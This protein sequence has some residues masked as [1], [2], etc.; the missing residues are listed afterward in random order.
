MFDRISCKNK[1]FAAIIMVLCVC[2]IA[3]AAVDGNYQIVVRSLGLSD[4][5]PLPTNPA[6]GA[7]V[8]LGSYSTTHQAGVTYPAVSL[9]T[10][11]GGALTVTYTGGTGHYYTAVKTSSTATGTFLTPYTV[12]SADST[13]SIFPNITSA[14]SKTI[15]FSGLKDKY[16]QVVPTL[17]SGSGTVTLSFTPAN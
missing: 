2:S 10:Y 17:N 13:V 4:A 16:M 12:S 15:Q 3:W 5:N 6:K 7:S 9:A 14:G 8:V 1:I 11:Q